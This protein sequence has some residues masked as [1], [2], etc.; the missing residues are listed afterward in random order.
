V[1]VGRVETSKCGC[2]YSALDTMA[3]GRAVN[4]DLGDTEKDAPEVTMWAI[5][6]AVKDFMVG[7]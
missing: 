3:S 1:V 4:D 7:V 6:R 5:V 2:M